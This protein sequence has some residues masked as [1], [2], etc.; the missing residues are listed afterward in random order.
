MTDEQKSIMSYHKMAMDMIFNSIA[1][2]SKESDNEDG[3]DSTIEWD[4]DVI[5]LTVTKDE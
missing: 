4:K 1:G 3:A 2:M 5:K